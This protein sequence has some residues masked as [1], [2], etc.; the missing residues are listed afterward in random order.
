MPQGLARQLDRFERRK[1]KEKIVARRGAFKSLPLYFSNDL[2]HGSWWYLFGSLFMTV[3]AS[4]VLW[5]TYEETKLG[6]DDSILPVL[7]FRMAWILMILSG[8]FFTIGSA[9]FMRAVNDPPMKPLFSCYHISTDELLGAWF[10]LLGV[11]P[12]IP[13]SIIF[14]YIERSTLF[15]C[16]LAVSII[17]SIGT[18]ITHFIVK[19]NYYFSYYF[20]FLFFLLLLYLILLIIIINIA[21]E[22]FSLC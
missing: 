3:I 19:I 6:T 18:P 22:H 17:C 15:W 1:E 13:Y 5:S 20:L 21:Q 7:E 11:I 16:A 14:L 2:V 8:L 10:F 9:A 4:V 12:A